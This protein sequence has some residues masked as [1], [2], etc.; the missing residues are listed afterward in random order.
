MLRG[1]VQGLQTGSRVVVTMHLH[2]LVL[3]F[4]LAWFG[5]L[6]SGI[7]TT[8]S[9]G[10]FVVALVS[11]GLFIFGAVIMAVGFYP[12]ALR[13]RRILEQNLEIRNANGKAQGSG[14]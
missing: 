3:V 10:P 11:S 9:S 1:N 7:L 13:A 5:I 14:A 6:G 8:F 2:P 4:M 12:E